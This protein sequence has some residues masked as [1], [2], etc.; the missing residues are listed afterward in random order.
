MK[1]ISLKKNHLQLYKRENSK[2]WQIKIKLPHKKALRV[3]SRMSV[4]KEAK[5]IANKKYDLLNLKNSNNINIY[6][7]HPIKKIHLINSKDLQ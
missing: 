2:I 6:K 3:S 4:L 1:K 7:K 5:E